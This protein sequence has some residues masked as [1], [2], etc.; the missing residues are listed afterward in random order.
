MSDWKKRFTQKLDVV[1]D[2]S[3]DQFDLV[4]D[5][6]LAPLFEEFRDFTATQGFAVAKP[7]SKPGLRTFR[8]GVAENCYTLL[9]FRLAGLEHA[10][11]YAEWVVPGWDKSQPLVERVE[12]ACFDAGWA[13]RMFERGLDQF[14][15][16]YMQSLG[17]RNES[18]ADLIE[19]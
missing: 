2:A 3:R 7:V 18:F 11:M 1:K 6:E 10:E 19:A 9:T 12:L 13:R 4:G 15:D 8:F 16:A 17:D 14:L 5:T